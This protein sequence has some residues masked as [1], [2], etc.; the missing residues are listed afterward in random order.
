M[1]TFGQGE[2]GQLGHGD[3]ENKSSP[4]LVQ[5]LVGKYMT[6][7]QCGHFHTMALTSSGYVFTWGVQK[8]EIL[9]V[10]M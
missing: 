2:N 8:R 9:V 1:Y 3:K 6:Q 4:V 7:V 10:V 5:A